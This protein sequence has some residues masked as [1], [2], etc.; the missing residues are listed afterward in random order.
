MPNGL[1]GE[2]A[3]SKRVEQLFIRVARDH[4]SGSLSSRPLAFFA[5]LWAQWTSE[6]EGGPR[7]RRTTLAS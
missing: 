3:G 1:E 5:G 2:S 6:N 7:H 4:Q